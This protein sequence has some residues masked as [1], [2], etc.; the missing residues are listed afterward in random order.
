MF[1]G[2][3]GS[4]L[5]SYITFQ[6]IKILAYVLL[7]NI[8]NEREDI[9][10]FFLFINVYGGI[11]A[12]YYFCLFFNIHFYIS[13]YYVVQK[14]GGNCRTVTTAGKIECKYSIVEPLP[15]IPL[16]CLYH[17][18][19]TRYHLYRNMKYNAQLQLRFLNEE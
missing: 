16:S 18:I 1:S 3:G 5:E 4:Y 11:N 6:R 9:L 15:T 10:K 19:H 17:L 7:S 2:D 8:T 13:P 14:I 12:F